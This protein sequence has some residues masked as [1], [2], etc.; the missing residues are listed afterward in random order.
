MEIIFF[1]GA[2]LVWQMIK[3]SL[4]GPKVPTVSMRKEV[5]VKARCGCEVIDDHV[6]KACSAHRI[7]S[8][9]V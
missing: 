7:L 4:R 5:R 6:I 3:N 1:V 2:C 9:L 8:E